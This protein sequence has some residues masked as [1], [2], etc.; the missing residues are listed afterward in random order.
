MPGRYVRVSDDALRLAAERWARAGQSG[1]LTADVKAIDIDVIIAAQALTFEGSSSQ[2]VIATTNPK[3]L[4]KFTTA[5][6]WNDIL[7]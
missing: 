1:H 7:P 5:R 6:L 2:L 4:A 3:H